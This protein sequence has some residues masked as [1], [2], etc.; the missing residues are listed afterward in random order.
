MNE[1][2]ET[3]RQTETEKKCLSI[4]DHFLQEL[5]EKRKRMKELIKGKKKRERKEEE[6]D[7]RKNEQGKKEIRTKRKQGRQTD[8]HK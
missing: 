7:E 6:T 4:V 3:D 2:K 5:R 1:N 8:R